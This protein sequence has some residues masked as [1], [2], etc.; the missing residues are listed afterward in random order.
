MLIGDAVVMLVVDR[1]RVLAAR[2]GPAVS[3]AGWWTFPT[4]TVEPHEPQ[5]ATAE[6]EAF[7][8]LGVR[9]RAIRK[10]WECPTDDGRFR[11]HWW[12]TALRQGGAPRPD[13]AEIDTICWID[14]AG[15]LRLRPTFQGDRRF[16]R[17]VLP[18]LLTPP[19][20]A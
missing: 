16:V 10:V 9:V 2:R 7:E 1:E 8:E 5:P 3:D 19:R 13:G 14:P 20:R 15:F 11:L 6:R 4:G 18:T 12:I 17:D